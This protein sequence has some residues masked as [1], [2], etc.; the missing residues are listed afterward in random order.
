[1]RHI[2]DRYI[3]LDAPNLIDDFKSAV[4]QSQL[5]MFNAPTSVGKTTFVR[6]QLKQ[7]IGT[8]GIERIAIAVP[9]L[10][11]GHNKTT[12]RTPFYYADNPYKKYARVYFCTYENLLTQSL[13]GT[14]VVF[15]EAH[16]LAGAGYRL[17]GF[18][19]VLNKALSEA[20]NVVMMSATIEQSVWTPM[21]PDAYR[22]DII[23]QTKQDCSIIMANAYISKLDKATGAMVNTTANNS[24]SETV[25][26]VIDAVHERYRIIVFIENRTALR[27]LEEKYKHLNPVRVTS[28]EGKMTLDHSD[29]AR[30]LIM[31]GKLPTDCR[32]VLMTSVGWQGID[33][34]EEVE[35]NDSFIV[36]NGITEQSQLSKV[37]ASWY[38]MMSRPRLQDSIKMIVVKN[39]LSEICTVA[40]EDTLWDGLSDEEKAHKK[41]IMNT[42]SHKRATEPDIYKAIVKEEGVEEMVPT[43]CYELQTRQKSFNTHA[44]NG[45]F[46]IEL[47]KYDMEMQEAETFG[48]EYENNTSS[49]INYHALGTLLERGTVPLTNALSWGKSDIRRALDGDIE[50]PELIKA[51][52]FYFK[53]TQEK[54][55]NTL[56]AHTR[57][58]GLLRDEV[59]AVKFGTL[60]INIEK[61]YKTFTFLRGHT[62]LSRLRKK[63]WHKWGGKTF[64][65]KQF[66]Q[67]LNRKD[68][69]PMWSRMPELKA[70]KKQIYSSQAFSRGI[71]AKLFVVKEHRANNKEKWKYTLTN[72]FPYLN[73]HYLVKWSFETLNKYH[74][75][76]LA[77][78][79]T[80]QEEQDA[81]RLYERSYD[82]LLSEHKGYYRNE[83]HFF[84]LQG[85]AVMEELSA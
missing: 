21:F 3:P 65:H 7:V 51:T 58:S 55:H 72:E 63:I 34:L 26:E 67:W 39:A 29:N 22:I 27:I 41:L 69:K 38:Q 5:I 9:T 56:E 47:E 50:V 84:M 42:A 33:I 12:D 8:N 37:P 18:A 52:M 11:I 17:K 62:H 77:E 71:F 75:V 16:E 28:I 44:Y 49:P 48:V 54:A 73:E 20:A 6:D 78:S 53:A 82:Q 25:A 66:V 64:T 80:P 32:L 30:E 35:D 81:E 59:F 79:E 23:P 40:D 10:M 61:A 31:N 4:L 85:G 13:E 83:E 24:T 60:H 36:I 70:H 15:D 14:L 2:I 68:V 74:E 1:M 57:L 76:A 45:G 43:L 19:E 46:A